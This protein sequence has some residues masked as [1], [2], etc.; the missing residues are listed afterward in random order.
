[1]WMVS[2]LLR[3]VRYASLYHRPLRVLPDTSPVISKLSSTSPSAASA[4]MSSGWK[5]SRCV[6]AA[7]RSATWRP[8]SFQLTSFVGDDRRA[9]LDL[10]VDASQESSRRPIIEGEEL[11]VAVDAQTGAAEDSAD[12]RGQL[13]HPDLLEV[14]EHAQRGFVLR[15]EEERRLRSARSTRFLPAATQSRC[16]HRRPC[17]AAG[18]WCR[19]RI[20]PLR[21][22]RGND[23]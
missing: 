19:R 13:H 16:P 4:G 15:R 10:R 8:S 7:V 3:T 23:R 22:Q 2:L 1:M 21:R 17:C 9:Y 5:V 6:Q 12:A 11:V 18:D 14:F 20:R